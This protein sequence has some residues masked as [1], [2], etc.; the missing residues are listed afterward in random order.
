MIVDTPARVTAT[1]VPDGAVVIDSAGHW[2]A[3]GAASSY[4]AMLAAGM[5]AGGINSAGRSKSEQAALYAQDSSNAARPGT[6]NHEKGTA[7]DVSTSSRAQA[8][9]LEHGASHGWV[10][11]VAG[12]PWHWHYTGG[13]GVLGGIKSAAGGVADT[14]TG[15][16]DAVRDKVADPLGL[17]TAGEGIR[18]LV[19]Q[20][21]FVVAALGLIVIGVN[22][23]VM[24]AAT[25]AVGQVIG[26]LT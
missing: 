12:E 1:G 14:V 19:L 17:N 23:M 25:K 13:G 3:S 21:V 22:R 7:L 6:S 2:L 9:L 15:W 24:P 16:V 5:P 20:G 8:W 10:Q 4:A 26:D 11:D 18:A